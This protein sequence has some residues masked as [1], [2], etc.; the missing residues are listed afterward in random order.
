MSSPE[1]GSQRMWR[2]GDFELGPC[3]GR[4]AFARVRL[5]RERQSLALAALKQVSKHRV[6]K[7][8][9]RRCLERELRLQ[10]HLSHPY[11]LQ[12]FGYFWDRNFIYLILEYAPHRDLRRLLGAQGPLGDAASAAMRPLAMAVEYLH[13]LSVIHRDIKPENLLIGREGIVK[14]SDFGWAVQSPRGERRWTVCG[15]LDY[16]APEMVRACGHGAAL[17]LWAVGAVAFECI[18]AVAPFAASSPEETYK[19]ILQSRFCLPDSS[20]P[21]AR[22]FIRRL[23]LTEPELRMSCEEA[24]AHEWLLEERQTALAELLRRSGAAF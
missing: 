20:A 8:R 23:L 16:L 6:A 2:L 24:L 4:G 22:D 21:N 17:D 7:L 5:A 1:N 18:T 11:V 13:S 10:A 12:L 19:R 14:L 3:L 9:A 15:T